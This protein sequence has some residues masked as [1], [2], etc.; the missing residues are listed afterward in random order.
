MTGSAITTRTTLGF[1]GCGTL[2]EAVV[3]GIRT[4]GREQPRILL[5]PRSEMVSRSLAET[6]A[7]VERA[8][9]NAEVVASADIVILAV[10]PQQ[11]DDA[12]ANL[13]F[14]PD[15]IVLSFLAKVSCGALRE[16]IG[17]GP[18]IARVT[19]LPSIELGKG[20][21]IVYPRLDEAIR[22]LLGLGEVIVARSEHEIMALG[23]AS[24]FLSTYFEVQN[25]MIDWLGRNGASAEHASLYVRS[26]LEG[27]A[28][29][30]RET[31]AEAVPALP[32]R[33]ETQAGLNE[34]SRSRLKALGWF[35]EIGRTL[36]MLDQNTTLAPQRGMRGQG[37]E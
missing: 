22:L 29:T 30:G 36:D 15:Q 20:P 9:S 33:H 17:D 24:G 18:R 27:L 28:A 25:V 11:I 31:A 6:F 37:G 4:H 5:S 1:V 13:D 32:G 10:R 14:R 16:R 3:R 26:M 34:R 35:D 21:I 8:S 12:L 23:Y 7:N 2:T 19:P